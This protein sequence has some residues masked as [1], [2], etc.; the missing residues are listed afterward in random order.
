MQRNQARYQTLPLSLRD[1]PP[2]QVCP[3][4]FWPT[5]LC[6]LVMGTGL[7]SEAC[8]DPLEVNGAPPRTLALQVGQEVDMRLQT[9][10]PGEYSSPPTI[11]SSAVRFLGASVVGP[12]VPA[13]P[14]QVFRFMAVARG[15]AVVTFHH[16]DD[17]PEVRDT[18]NVH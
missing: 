9:V 6:G 5:I 3:P 17:D 18:M 16:T 10:G 15:Q 7:L 4:R 13:G 2:T 1:D 12:Y 14:T 8:S 11:S